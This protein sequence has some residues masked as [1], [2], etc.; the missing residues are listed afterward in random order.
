MFERERQPVGINVFGEEPEGQK[1]LSEVMQKVASTGIGTVEY[2]KEYITV[3]T[4]SAAFLN[5]RRQ[6]TP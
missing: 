4:G 5:L 1:K 3:S 2:K 6:N